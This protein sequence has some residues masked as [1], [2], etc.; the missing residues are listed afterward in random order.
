MLV[1][2]AMLLPVLLL[3]TVLVIDGGRRYIR[4]AELKYLASSAAHS[5]MIEVSN[6]LTQRATA[7]FLTVCAEAP[8]PEFCS[9]QNIYAF[10]TT[11]EIDQIIQNPSTRSKIF[12]NVL[13]YAKSFDPQTRDPIK[14]AEV[15]MVFPMNYTYGGPV[16]TLKVDLID[17]ETLI[18]NTFL[19]QQGKT[20]F[21]FQATANSSLPLN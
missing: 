7:N 20:P 21:T 8:P 6:L 13:A 5:G 3:M 18:F 1:F 16:V 10:L 9:S 14:E 4:F 2:L 19:T 11:D 12:S 17:Q 15:S